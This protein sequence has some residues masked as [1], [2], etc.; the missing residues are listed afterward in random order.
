MIYMETPKHRI[1][2]EA[3]DLKLIRHPKKELKVTAK[4][5]SETEAYAKLYPTEEKPNITYISLVSHTIGHCNKNDCLI[6]PEEGVATYKT[7]VSASLNI[8][9]QS[10]EIVGFCVSSYLTNMQ[11]NKFLSDDAA[12]EIMANDGK[13]N[14]GQVFAVWKLSNPEVANLI[15]ENFDENSSNFNKVKAS[16]EYY[17][18]DYQFFVSRGTADYPDGKFFA[19]DCEDCD[20]MLA[21]LKTQG[22]TGFYKGNRISISPIGGFQGGCALTLNPANEFSNL[23]SIK[24]G[25]ETILQNVTATGNS[26][27]TESVIINTGETMESKETKTEVKQVVAAV[28]LTVDK[29]VV[30]AL[31]IELDKKIGELNAKENCFTSL[32]ATVNQI[33]ADLEASKAEAVKAAEM[34]SKIQAE[35]DKEVIARQALEAKQIEDAKKAVTASRLEQISKVIEVTD[36]NRAMFEK[37]CAE[38]TD[39]DFAKK[40]EFY[41][42]VSKKAVASVE[43]PVADVKAEVKAALAETVKET[44]SVSISVAA[45]SD[46]L[47]DR[48]SKAFNTVESFGYKDKKLAK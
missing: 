31:K 13:V 44:K 30:D 25:E 45:P 46:T 40:L 3:A 18:N 9:H 1:K 37:E 16:F 20:A 2:F 10:D 33:K 17:F 11:N 22:G 35:L 26:G 36:A 32:E 28:E 48:F 29:H 15:E 21:S 42:S 14:V 12:Q 8:E 5:L 41:K 24:D 19:S 7:G 4:K 43:A 39:E 23:T 27:A 38:A 6:T 34:A 47:T